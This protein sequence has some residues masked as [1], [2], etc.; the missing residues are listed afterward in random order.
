ML[1]GTDLYFGA[2]ESVELLGLD[3]EYLL[4]DRK[5][6]YYAKLAKEPDLKQTVQDLGGNLYTI[7]SEAELLKNQLFGERISFVNLPEY[8]NKIVIM[9][10]TLDDEHWLIQMNYAHYHKSKSYLKTLFTQ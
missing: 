7:T 10:L 8:K 4:K 6:F 3:P 5:G 1:S 9:L 2:V